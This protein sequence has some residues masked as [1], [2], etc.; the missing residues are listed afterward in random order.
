MKHWTCI[1]MGSLKH[2]YFFEQTIGLLL[3]TN[4]VPT[5]QNHIRICYEPFQP[6]KI[7]QNQDH[8]SIN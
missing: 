6:K 4:L 7:I 2:N 1:E 8:H 3:F 5:E